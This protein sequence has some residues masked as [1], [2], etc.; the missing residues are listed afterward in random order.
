MTSPNDSPAYVGIKAAQLLAAELHSAVDRNEFGVI[1]QDISPLNSGTLINELASPSFTRRQRLRTSL[2]AEDA[3]VEAAIARHPE[4]SELLSA[5]EEAAV[6]WRNLN[7][8]TIAVI[9]NRPLS[10]AASLRD[11]RVISE[12]DL[13][14]RLCAEERD[15]ADVSWL[16]TLWDA[17]D[18]GK[19][20]RIA[21]SDIIEFSVALAALP[22]SERS[23]RASQHLYLLKLFPDEHLADEK[24]DS[25][26]LRRLQ[27]NRELVVSERPRHLDA[28]LVD[29]RAAG[30]TQRCGSSCPMSRLSVV[31]S[32]VST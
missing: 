14:K 13:T 21:L 8:R 4:M 20:L 10:K 9:T 30:G 15:K 31:G 27:Q 22:A 5:Q 32:R 3:T 17:I 24:S 7:Q 28:A 26:L 18:R 11:F 23:T 19:A 2:V 6:A 1:A 16:R 25:R 29:Q 12:R